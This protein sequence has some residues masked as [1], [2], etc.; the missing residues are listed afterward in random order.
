MPVEVLLLQKFQDGTEHAAESEISPMLWALS[1]CYEIATRVQTCIQFLHIEISKE[2][3]KCWLHSEDTAWQ[4]KAW[5]RFWRS[6]LIIVTS[7]SKPFTEF[8][9]G[10][11]CA[12]YY[13]PRHWALLPEN[14]SIPYPACEAFTTAALCILFRIHNFG[15]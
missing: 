5:Y 9:N 7:P 4:E 12:L 13:L 14:C 8:V 6:S 11:K 10:N 15:M 1:L 2:N 3:I